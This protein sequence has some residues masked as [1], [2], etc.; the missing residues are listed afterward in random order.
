MTMK[1]IQGHR[2]CP[3]LASHISLT[4]TFQDLFPVFSRTYLSRQRQAFK[5][6]LAN[7]VQ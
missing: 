3:Y 2:S 4:R 7:Q 1:V 5:W 6:S